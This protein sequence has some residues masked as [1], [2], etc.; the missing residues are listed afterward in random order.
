M[1]LIILYKQFSKQKFEYE[2]SRIRRENGLGGWTDVTDYIENS[3]EYIYSLPTNIGGLSIL[4]FSSVDINTNFT[5]DFGSD[6]VRVIYRWNTRNGVL[7]HRICKHK[8]IDTLFLNLE[9]TIVNNC[10][11]MMF[12]LR[13]INWT[14]NE[15]E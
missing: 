1:E 13:S 7:Y 6:A 5:R 12:F 11:V 9:K 15:E 10:N 4:I 2:L 3:W 8:R 14:K